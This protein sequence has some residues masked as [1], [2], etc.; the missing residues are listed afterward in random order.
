VT[1]C[2]SFRLVLVVG[3]ATLVATACAGDDSASEV[4]VSGV[5]TEVTGDLSVV[6]SFVVLDGDG[7]SHLFYP[8]QG[9]L[10]LGGPL[11]HLR[12]HVLSGERVTVIF[13]ETSDGRLIAVLV[14][15]QDDEDH[16]RTG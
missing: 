16:G 7:D 15:H 4:S 1:N 2:R 9:L 3:L 6:S 11:A 14:E 8:E 12:D 13:E 10:F 5:V